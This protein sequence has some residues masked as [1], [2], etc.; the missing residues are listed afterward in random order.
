MKFNRYV[1]FTH[2][3][4]PPSLSSQASL[5]SSTVLSY[6][7]LLPALLD[8]WV[9]WYERMRELPAGV[10]VGAALVAVDRR[11]QVMVVQQVIADLTTAATGVLKAEM[12]QL[13]AMVVGKEEGWE[14]VGEDGREGK[15][16]GG[17]EGGG[18][19]G[20]LDTTALKAIT[21]LTNAWNNS[22]AEAIHSGSTS[23]E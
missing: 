10:G 5:P 9:Q 8:L 20:G 16:G 21:A 3:L 4:V 7:L 18:G 13:K 1:V 6:P 15:E 14:V 12:A 17:G 2:L 23:I 22:G 19:G 11:V